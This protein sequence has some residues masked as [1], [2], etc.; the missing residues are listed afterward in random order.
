[1]NKIRLE[2]PFL[3][4]QNEE[5]YDQAVVRLNMPEVNGDE[6]LRFFIEEHEL[7]QV[8]LSEVGSQGVVSEILSGKQELNIRQ[9]RA[10]A[11][12]FHVSPAIFL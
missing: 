2:K 12:R 8:D 1:M 7:K 9:I 3:S 5:E 4:F 11:Q 10:L 6:M